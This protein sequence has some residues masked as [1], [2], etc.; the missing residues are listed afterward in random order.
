MFEALISASGIASPRRTRIDSERMAAI[1][2]DIDGVLHVSGEPVPGG[3]DAVRAPEGRRAIGCDSSPTA[4]RG[5]QDG[6]PRELRGL[7][8]ELEADESCDDPGR[9]CGAPGRR[10]CSR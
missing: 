3:G 5:A 9:G 10:G 1:L 8:V 6:S 2:L 7:G 4:R